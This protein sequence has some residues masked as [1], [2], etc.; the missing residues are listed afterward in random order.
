MQ[1]KINDD[2]I[3]ISSDQTDTESIDSKH[4]VSKHGDTKVFARAR[5]VF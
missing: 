4:G 5:F 3:F 1:F 2:G